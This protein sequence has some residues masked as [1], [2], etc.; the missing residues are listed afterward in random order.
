MGGKQLMI[1]APKDGHLYAF[2]LSDNRQVFRVPATTIENADVR[3]TADKLPLHCSPSGLLRQTEG[4]H[5][6]RIS[7]SS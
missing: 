5:E 3:F 6:R 4:L 1:V 2:D 7:G